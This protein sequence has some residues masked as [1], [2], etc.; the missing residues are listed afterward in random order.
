MD[1]VFYIEFLIIKAMACKYYVSWNLIM[2]LELRTCKKNIT[3]IFLYFGNNVAMEYCFWHRINNSYPVSLS[4]IFNILS[5]T[6]TLN[7]NAKIKL[8]FS[9]LH[10]NT[11]QDSQLSASG[12]MSSQNGVY[13]EAC[14]GL[15]KGMR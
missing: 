13:C 8:D 1:I 6:A 14:G 11:T 4:Y 15:V 3:Y 12:I 5:N 7:Y 9:F 2:Y 10:V